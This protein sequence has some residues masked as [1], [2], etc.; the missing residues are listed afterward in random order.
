AGNP[1][2]AIQALKRVF[3]RD[4]TNAAAWRKLSECFKALGRRTES[5]LA[6]APLAALGQ[7]NDLELATL[8]Q[9]PP[10][11]ATAPA[12]S[13]DLAELESI[14]LVPAGDPA[15]RLLGALSEVLEKVYPP[16]LERFGV[17]SRDRLGARSTHPFRQLADR[18]AA[19]FGVGE[20]ELYLHQVQ[21]TALEIE[22]T[23][24][25]SILVPPFAQKLNEAGQVF[26]LGRVFAQIARR[27]HPIER[28]APDALELL[29][30]AAARGVVSEFP[31]P[32]RAGDDAV[33]ALARR[34]SRALPWLGRGSIEDAARAYAASPSVDFGDW[35]V[36]ARLGAA[37]AALL[38]TDDL[39]AAVLVT[40][41]TEGDL[42][43]AQGS[44]LA[45]GTRLTRDLMSFWLSDGALAV[46]RR[47]GVL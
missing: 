1:A 14:A 35:V 15:G 27:L 31:P 40:R 42:S 47:L 7:A 46:R 4:V 38:V 20:F 21:A 6:L 23:D 19:I 41:Q 28:L 33:N 16:E 26:V 5:T 2:K 8:S 18:V 12:R 25:V 17:S 30:A 3:D 10:R 9:S 32:L 43:G 29:L 11:P 22:F 37:R 39:P 34:V 44:A 24:P 36:R 45:T 13:F